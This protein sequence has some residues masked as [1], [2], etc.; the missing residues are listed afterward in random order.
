MISQDRS[1]AEFFRS[2]Y[3]PLRLPD[4]APRT[5]E[6]YRYA[7]NNMAKV[8][9][10]EATL[11]DLT[12]ETV[13]SLVSW[14]IDRG[15]SPATANGD[16]KRIVALWNFAAKR[17]L[18]SDWPNVPKLKEPIREPQA[19]SQQEISRLFAACR[20]MPGR[21][22]G[23]LAWRWWAGLHWVLWETGE[24]I[25]AILR[26]TWND[27][28]PEGWLLV[29]AEYRKGGREDKLSK[30]SGKATAAL[31]AIRLPKRELIFPWDRASTHL[32]NR[33][34]LVLKRAGLP[35]GRRN[36]FHRMRRSVASHYE[37]RG[38]N[39]TELLGHADR[40]T[41][42]LYLDRRIVGQPHAADLLFDPEG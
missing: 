40:K 19:W 28:D 42:K 15:N 4:G 32:W 34:R 24:R 37:A 6:Q 25:G 38:G 7:L 3:R 35:I 22:S 31:D 29:R 16:R 9:G 14:H 27:Y 10:H 8:L 1:L 41:T 11:C 18:V 17:G 20:A 36:M 2:V 33:Y 12:D 21:I 13:A 39:A 26:L 30:L 5:L 23:I